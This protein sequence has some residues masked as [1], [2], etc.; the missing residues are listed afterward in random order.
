MRN[1]C[2]HPSER[3]CKWRR[4]AQ[5][6]ASHFQR[7]VGLAGAAVEIVIVTYICEARIYFEGLVSAPIP[8]R[9]MLMRHSQAS[10]SRLSSIKRRRQYA[11]EAG[12]P[13]DAYSACHSLLLQ[14]AVRLNI[15]TKVIDD[16]SWPERE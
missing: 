14:A 3:R 6:G 9:D 4:V 1:K 16:L 7:I 5:R 10:Q 15:D 11:V 8:W 2:G 13:M 12:R